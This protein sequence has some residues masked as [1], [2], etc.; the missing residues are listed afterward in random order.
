VWRR[1]A[2]MSSPVYLSELEVDR[3]HTTAIAAKV[4]SAV[5]G[6][7]GQKAWSCQIV[8]QMVTMAR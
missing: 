4:L 1:D 6:G 8:D 7:A 2:D 3:P 5:V